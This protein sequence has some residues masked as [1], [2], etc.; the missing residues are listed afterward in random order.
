MF[1]SVTRV[2]VGHLLW[3]VFIHARTYFS[4]YHD[5]M[6][7]PPVSHL[8]LMVSALQGGSLTGTFGTPLS[9][10]FREAT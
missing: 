6:G 2:Q 5:T 7:T 10:M 3:T 9:S 4:T 8:A 1:Q